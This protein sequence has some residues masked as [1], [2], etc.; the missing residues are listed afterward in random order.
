[1]PNKSDDSPLDRIPAAQI[2]DAAAAADEMSSLIK[3]FK[4]A[5]ESDG[6]EEAI[7]SAER[8]AAIWKAISASPAADAVPPDR[9][10][11]VETDLGKVLEAVEAEEWD[12]TLLV[13]LDY[14]LYQGFRDVKQALQIT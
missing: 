13:D 4:I 11:Q 7:A 1:M 3:A 12:K 6:K 9:I 14:S 2:E 5:V 8:M 10:Q